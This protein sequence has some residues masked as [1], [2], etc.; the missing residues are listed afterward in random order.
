MHAVYCKLWVECLSSWGIMR[1]I[2]QFSDANHDLDADNVL[3][4]TETS[5]ILNKCSGKSI[6]FTSQMYWR[7]RLKYHEIKREYSRIVQLHSIS[8]INRKHGR[9]SVAKLCFSFP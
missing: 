4:L 6:I 8:V 9:L 7:G 2:H 5:N 1:F 3:H